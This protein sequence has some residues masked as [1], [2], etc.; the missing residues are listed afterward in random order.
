MPLVAAM[1]RQ[2]GFCQFN[3]CILTQLPYSRSPS[4]RQQY[5][6][7]ADYTH[8]VAVYYV[9]CSLWR[10]CDWECHESNGSAIA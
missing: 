7:M 5:T 8:T 10:R 6:A 2:F 4:N 9:V 1:M 3:F